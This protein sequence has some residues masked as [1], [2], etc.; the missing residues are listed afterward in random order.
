MARSNQNGEPTRRP[1]PESVVEQLAELWCEVFMAN[2]QRH[3]IAPD[4]APVVVAVEG[5]LCP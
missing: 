1:L 3:P 5:F 2:L 4:R